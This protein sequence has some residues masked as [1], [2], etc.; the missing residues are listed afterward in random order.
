[1]SFVVFSS[2][3]N[4]SQTQISYLISHISYLN[5]QFNKYIYLNV[6]ALF[7]SFVYIVIP[8]LFSNGKDPFF[9]PGAR[10]YLG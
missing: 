6:Q 8:N 10:F 7:K 3:N 9:L 5:R 1:M 4:Y 2:H